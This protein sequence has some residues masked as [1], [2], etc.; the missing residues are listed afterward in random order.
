MPRV[1]C[2]DVGGGIG[3]L[4]CEQHDQPG[5]DRALDNAIDGDM[6]LGDALD[7]RAH[8]WEF[9]GRQPNCTKAAR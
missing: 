8:Q 3:L 1:R 2:F 9:F 4:D 6:S 7:D 5:L